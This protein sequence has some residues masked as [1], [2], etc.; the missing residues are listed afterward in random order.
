MEKWNFPN[1]IGAVDGKHIR[2]RKP[3]DSGSLYF[4]YK[5]YFSV[6]L[7]AVVDSDYKFVFA[8][9]GAEGRA[10]DSRLFRDSNFYAD[11]CKESNPLNVPGPVKLKGME[12]SIPFYFIGDDAFALHSNMLKPF[13]G[14]G[15]DYIEA[16][17]NYRICRPRRVVENSFGIL[18][19]RF[20][21]FHRTQDMEPQGVKVLVMAAVALHNFL[22]VRSPNAYIPAGHA[23]W[24]DKTYRAKRGEWRFEKVL[25]Q[26]QKMPNQNYT[27]A[28][29]KLRYD[30]GKYVV[31]RAGSVPW[32][33]QRI[34]ALMEGRMDTNGFEED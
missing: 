9:V 29:K 30:L 20:R 21:I 7:L 25:D 1:I 8:D 13:P 18:S 26:V 4:N 11:I 28:V 15:L 33:N 19:S 24:E 5:H 17:F 23:D 6:V 27:Q 34:L 22:R 10:G 16:G 3:R 2:I 12:S 32:Q 31:S 14:I